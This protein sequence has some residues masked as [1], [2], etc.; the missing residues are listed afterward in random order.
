MAVRAIPSRQERA[1]P[2]EA[3]KGFGRLNL[4]LLPFTL[5]HDGRP[6]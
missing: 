6:Q 3:L 4:S 2:L 1:V 5:K